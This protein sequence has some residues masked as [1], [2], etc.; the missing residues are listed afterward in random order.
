[1]P[2]QQQ[3]QRSRSRV[4]TPP[5]DDDLD[6]RQLEKNSMPRSKS[7]SASASRK[8]LRDDGASPVASMNNN[9]NGTSSGKVRG[10]ESSSSSS[11]RAK[12][13]LAGEASRYERPPRKSSDAGVQEYSRSLKNGS[14]VN[15]GSGGGGGG[16]PTSSSKKSKSKDN[17][18]VYEDEGSTLV[19]GGGA[20]AAAV[21]AAAGGDDEED[22]D[23]AIAKARAKRHRK[24]QFIKEK[25]KKDEDELRRE[26]EERQ[27]KERRRKEKERKELHRRDTERRLKEVER[28]IIE[29]G[30]VN[31]DESIVVPDY[32]DG[33]IRALV[34][35][36]TVS[37]TPDDFLTMD[38]F[39][40]YDRRIK[41][42]LQEVISDFLSE[43]YIDEPP[44]NPSAGSEVA[45]FL[46]IMEANGIVFKSAGKPRECYCKMEFGERPDDGAVKPKNTD[47]YMTEAI[48]SVQNPFLWNQH[49]N[50]RAC[51]I[52]DKIIV[53]VWDQR[54][55]EF[56]GQVILFV[57][58][59][60]ERNEIDGYV[61]RWFD[62]YPR[63]GKHKDKYVGGE[64]LLEF[65][66]DRSM[67][68]AAK[69]ENNRVAYY[70]NELLASKINFMALYNVLLRG[71]LTLDMLVIDI[72]ES[73]V[74]L[75]S[76]ESK[77]VLRVFGQKWA[78]GEAAQFIAYVLLLFEKYKVNEV[79][80][81]AVFVAYESVYKKVKANPNWLTKYE[82]PAL[83]DL[84][85]Q[86][87]E[88]FRL[89]VVKYKEFF[90]KNRPPGALENTILLWRMV[91]KSEVYRE[92]HPEQPAAFTPF[93]N[94]IIRKSFE[95]RFQKLFE[96][97]SPVDEGDLEL[98]VEG[99]VRLTDMIT[100]EIEMDAKYYQTPFR[101]DVK[102]VEVS[103]EMY[104]SAFMRVI[105]EQQEFFTSA[106]GVA[107]ASKGI[108]NLLKRMRRMDAKLNK[109]APGKSHVNAEKIFSPFVLKWLDYINTKT[110][111]W[112]A[113]ATSADK[114]EP[115]N[116]FDNGDG[117]PAHSSSIMDVFTAINHEL[118]FIIDLK[119]SNKVQSAG[120]FQKFSKTIYTALEQ[121]CD[122]IGTGE[123]K[124]NPNAGKAWID[125][126]MKL[127]TDKKGPADIASES[128]V[129]LCNVEFALSKLDELSQIM[130]VAALSQTTKSYRATI[131]PALK[132]K[133]KKSRDPAS[134]TAADEEDYISGGMKVQIMY[135]E[136][137][138]PVTNTGLA[139]AYATIR[140]PDGTVVPAPDPMD[141]TGVD[142]G[143]PT[144]DEVSG[145]TVVAVG[146][147]AAVPVA[148]VL[149]GPQCEMAR[150]RVISD[151]INPHWD[152]EFTILLPPVSRLDVNVF[153]K[154]LITNDP[155]CG[156]ASLD[157][158]SKSRLRRKLLDH[159]THDIFLELE[160]QGRI[161]LRMALD[162]EE[163]D[164]GFWFKKAR[165][166]L[167]RTRND[168]VR[169]LCTRIS[170]YPREVITKA[171]KEQEAAPVPQG[172]LGVFMQTQYSNATAAGVS[173]DK[174]VSSR[175]A[176][177]ILA[178]LTDYLNKNLDTLFSGLSSKMAT[179]VI[180]KIWEES[181]LIIESCLI[182]Q[183]YGPIEKDRRV[184][185]K[186][187]ISILNWTLDILK[188]F[189][190]A[191]GAE[192]GLPIKTLE[193]RKYVH[194]A[195]LLDSY[196][197]DLKKLKSDYEMSLIQGR[198]KEYI[199]RLIRVRIEKDDGLT[200]QQRDEAR[201]WFE[202]QLVN[203]KEKLK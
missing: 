165:E 68:E 128:C 46:K 173:I 101:R 145:P 164:V 166:K 178:P 75:L 123:F 150:T 179:E 125:T 135:A 160:P 31:V 197:R 70:E 94:E 186:R 93:I 146:G 171:L 56:L 35:D 103:I 81:N 155:V 64:I 202:V 192:L 18:F 111:E 109:I 152:E 189:F 51:K 84:S 104:M 19:N 174:T 11:A 172:Y 140:V 98:V 5:D 163:E 151:S 136:N 58:E 185:N 119:W 116:D 144:G 74:D 47:T 1:M 115:I 107:A 129:K 28:M 7:Q 124:P 176:D 161:L 134:P 188:Q 153:S 42:P 66:V 4:R 168:F 131:A 110:I 30:F 54:K 10:D 126:I 8:Q 184:L 32:A 72:S 167:G 65:N 132:E 122:V 141:V 118:S 6:Q 159:Q 97:T 198:D 83:S 48:S 121:Y 180:K 203:R 195:K 44:S 148:T 23:V 157:F 117:D 34:A 2:Q 41:A 85:D 95:S 3:P 26:E 17:Q 149:K 114:F 92:S 55:D 63:Q 177:D 57:Q 196:D 14:T 91:F 147:S 15:G 21:A 62:L 169:S 175:E 16:S 143:S 13:A 12:A 22:M 102:I 194:N 200:T 156:E 199:L 113:N 76:D 201:K 87:C 162:G 37:P 127:R 158:A 105:D 80:V 49:M 86:M 27:E 108:F 142:A 96:L 139:N 79:P 36:K 67:T 133:A 99:L 33:L 69:R 29:G 25:R 45:I 187:Q 43:R 73:T 120:F 52:T 9:N 190:H 89:Q 138:R 40:S 71:C 183:L 100:D 39:E 182:P 137:I 88:Y 60:V 24:S 77:T 181:L 78:I 53:S 130:N 106:E 50:I 154:N 82:R 191:D 61:S 193:T 170:P 90:P 20:A 59:I 112:V 38:G